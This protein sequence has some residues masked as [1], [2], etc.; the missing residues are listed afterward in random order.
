NIEDFGVFVRLD[1]GI[2]ALLP[3]SE[4]DLPS[5]VTP[6][7]KY[8]AG[9][10]VTLRVLDV[11]PNERKMALT[12]KEAADIEG[13]GKKTPS[14]KSGGGSTSGGRQAYSDDGG[15]EGGGFGTLGD[16]LG[17]QLDGDEDE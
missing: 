17:D 1:S 9:E 10:D 2:T 11:D 5:G 6:H 3:R 8:T 14:K 16:L 15:D 12:E 7:R 13:A 4:M